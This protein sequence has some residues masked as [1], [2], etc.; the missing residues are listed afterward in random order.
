M[1]KKNNK[2]KTV[3]ERYRVKNALIN[4]YLV[5][6]FTVFPLFFAN[7]YYSIRHDK[8]FVFLIFSGI[9]IVVES[10]ILLCNLF[11]KTNEDKLHKPKWYTM[12]SITDCAFGVLILSSGISTLFSA[13]PLDSLTG[14]QG[15]NNGLILMI[16][17]FLVYI[18]I[19]RT[20]KFKEY[21]FITFA[22]ASA[23]VSVLCILNFF[24][25]DP[26]GM[27]KG[28]SAQVVNDFTST[29]GNKN[30]MSSFCCIT[31]PVL[32]MLFMN[33]ENKIAKYI[34]LTSSSIGFAGIICAD[35]DSGFLGLI[36]LLVIIFLYYIRNI[37]KLK[38]Y[39]IG[40]S[41]MLIS[42][43]VLA[44][45]CLYLPEKSLGA[46]QILLLHSK[47][48]Y[49]LLGCSVILAVALW[50]AD[51]K[52]ENYLL[53]KAV[54]YI[55]IGIFAV[56]IV[57]LMGLII[58]YT[59]I[60]AKTPLNSFMKYFRFD[61]KWGTHRGFM[62]IKSMDIV[63]N[64]SAKDILFGCGP[65]TFKSAFAPYFDELNE[66]YGNTATN[67]AHNELLNYL[68]TIGIVGLLS[69]LTM[70][71][72]VI[73]RAVKYR[74]QNPLTIVFASAVLCY[75]MQSVVNIAQPITTPLFFIFIA[76]TESA[77]RQAKTNIQT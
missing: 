75:L 64:S 54:Q 37:H 36:P 11:S 49:I 20:Y 68:I 53:P 66:K 28:Y 56:G 72:S 33:S 22:V 13:Y 15:R 24:G 39:F 52:F 32:L 14:N 35:S 17:Y 21:V 73:V 63:K 60:D 3:K 77:V 50:I 10:I 38:D 43:K 41:L 40:I 1:S 29:I 12:L 58:Y 57:A 62:W 8:L 76:L 44:V 19:S 46:I 55:A 25:I 30:L 9:L 5:L 31:I 26:L 2:S 27:Y 16:F 69:Y 51:R 48:S 4:Y 47:L 6:M 61:E 74:K 34:Y 45:L 71:I 67:C 65:D 7:K 70:V 42:G 59:F 18:I 23:V